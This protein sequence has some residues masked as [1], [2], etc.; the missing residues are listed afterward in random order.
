MNFT[1]F[2]SNKIDKVIDK[3]NIKRIY[4][5]PL[6]PIIS[7]YI[8]EQFNKGKIKGEKIISEKEFDPVTKRVVNKE[9]ILAYK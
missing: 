6:C 7:A 9:Y 3:S 4:L 2:D 1:L 5:S 8:K